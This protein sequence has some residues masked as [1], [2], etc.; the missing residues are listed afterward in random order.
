MFA[1]C[2]TRAFPNPVSLFFS[3]LIDLIKRLL[4]KD[5]T[6]RL[7]G[8]EIKAH[9]FY[10]EVAWDNIAAAIPPLVPTLESDDDGSYFPPVH[11]DVIEAGML[12]ELAHER[13]HEGNP[14]FALSCR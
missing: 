8:Q 12:E 3:Q 1:S 9:A 5:P 4:V 6:R 10:S 7:T 13:C 2:P 11:S 14:F